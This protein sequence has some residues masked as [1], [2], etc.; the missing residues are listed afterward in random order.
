[1]ACYFSDKKKET[2]VNYKTILDKIKVRL[3][4]CILIIEYIISMVTIIY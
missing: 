2:V 4:T 3:P 1:M